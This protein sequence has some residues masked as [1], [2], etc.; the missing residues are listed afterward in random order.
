MHLECEKGDNQIN[1]AEFVLKETG[2]TFVSGLV[3]KVI[4]SIQQKT[5][6]FSAGHHPT[7]TIQT[8]SPVFQIRENVS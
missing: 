8:P 7:S 2:S 6:Q 3:S 5:A 1:I 4:Q